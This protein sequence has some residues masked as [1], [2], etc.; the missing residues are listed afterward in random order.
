MIDYERE[1]EVPQYA[2]EKTALARTFAIVYGWMGAG[3]A[4]SGLVAWMTFESGFWKKVAVGPGLWVCILAELALVWVLS[5]SMDKLPLVQAPVLFLGYA[6]LNGLTLSVV[7]VVYKLALV[8]NVF[9]ITA[10]MFAGLAV[11]GSVTKSDL[12]SIGS[13]CGM[14]LWGVIVAMVV[15]LF[16]GSSGLDWL[17]SFVAILIFTGLTMYDAQRIR[18]IADRERSMDAVALQKAGILGA[19]ALYLDFINLFIHLLRM[20]GRER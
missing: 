14:A 4:L 1:F 11:W 3:L 17:I 5:R 6:A 8:Q 15:N 20:F 16:V 9:F 13:L 19:L 2:A 12:S 7:F 18:E 10:G